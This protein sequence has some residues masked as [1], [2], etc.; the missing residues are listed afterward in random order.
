M[1]A[2]AEAAYGQVVQAGL[3]PNPTVGYQVDQWQP[4]LNNGQ[5]GAFVNQIIK[6]AEKLPLAQQVAGYDYINALVAVRKAEVEVMTGVRSAYFAAM[7]AKQSLDVN[8]Q[9]AA[10]ADE[11]YRLQLRQVAAGEAAGYEP[12]QAYAQ[13]VQA[14]NACVQAAAAWQVAWKQLAAAVGQPELTPSPLDGQLDLALRSRDRARL[15]EQVLDNHTEILTARNVVAQA[16]RNL[17]LQQ[18]LPYP[19]LQTNSYYQRDTAVNVFQFGVQLGFQWPIS[20]KNQGNIRTACAKIAVA[21]QQLLAARN[22]LSGRLAEAL[23]RY[24]ANVGVA[25][26]YRDRII[27]PLTQAYRA[28]VRRY[29]VEPEKVGFNDIVVAQQNLAAALQGYLSILDAQ[30][31]AAIDLAAV[32]QSDELIP[33]PTENR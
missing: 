33:E 16:Q 20:D 24:E 14:R 7:I 10:M 1:R 23:G 13:A 6:T 26:N 32:A 8:R 2:E 3:H 28:I 5:Q 4:R 27:P 17:L 30:W 21:E 15:E 31:K 25:A 9:L 18:R 19:D 11:V 29:Q 22:S 12:L